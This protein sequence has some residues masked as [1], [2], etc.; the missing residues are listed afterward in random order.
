MAAAAASLL[1]VALLLGA[2]AG[3]PS[4]ADP[5]PENLARQPCT[6]AALAIW[7]QGDEL[8][9]S[10]SDQHG[11]DVEVWCH[12]TIVRSHWDVRVGWDALQGTRPVHRTA[13][14]AGC[15][16]DF[17]QSTGPA[18]T[19]AADHRFARVVWTNQDPANEHKK[20]TFSYD[21]GTGAVT[22]TGTRPGA[23]PITRVVAAQPTWDDLKAQLPFPPD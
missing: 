23:P 6:D 11:H 2:C 9:E 22:I 7:A 4:T 1:L 5:S 21:F 13:T 15:F 3:A 10:F 12:R 18:I 8:R 17:G 14:I 20:Y 16:F 19:E